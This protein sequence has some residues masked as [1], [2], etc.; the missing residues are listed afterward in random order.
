[1]LGDGE[2]DGELLGEDD[3]ELEGLELGELEG[4]SLG[5]EDGL[6]LGLEDGEDEGLDEGEELGED[7]GEL[8]GEEEGD[9]PL[10]EYSVALIPPSYVLKVESVVGPTWSQLTEVTASV[11]LVE[12]HGA[13]A[14][15]DSLQEPPAT[16]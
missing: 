16:R 5:E 4:L 13:F 8:E 11:L 2:D 9:E 14:P 1:L 12:P 15:E 6:E 3:G 10:A 7:D